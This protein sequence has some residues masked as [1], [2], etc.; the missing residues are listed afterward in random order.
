MSYHKVYTLTQYDENVPLLKA[1][2]QTL[3]KVYSHLV[4]KHYSWIVPP[5][6][7]GA[8]KAN[9]HRERSSDDVQGQ[10][11]KWMRENYVFGLERLQE[12]THHEHKEIQ[13][14]SSYFYASLKMHIVNISGYLLVEMFHSRR[15]G[16]GLEGCCIYS[17]YTRSQLIILELF[18]QWT[19]LCC[20][21]SLV[22]VEGHTHQSTLKG[23]VYP[24]N[25]FH[26]IVSCLL[27]D[28]TNRGDLIGQFADEYLHYDDVRYYWLKNIA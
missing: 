2:I 14:S 27:D 1:A 7:R 5:S 19:T 26:S 28:D 4:S 10:Y 13:V 25:L 17:N 20:L 16:M 22:Q 8:V 12:L 3:A 21:V 23:Y 11:Q 15:M 18:L 6:V 9:P 24:N